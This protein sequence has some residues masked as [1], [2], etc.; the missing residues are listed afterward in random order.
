MWK[1]T[2]LPRIKPMSQFYDDAKNGN[3]PAFSWIDPR[4]A[5]SG[6]NEGSNDQHPDHDVALGEAL[7]KR[8]YE[9]LRAGPDW[10]STLLIV[11]YARQTDTSDFCRILVL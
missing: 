7:M 3:L 6:G 8:V 5:L 1:P 4:L 10:D 2:S 9:S 11:T